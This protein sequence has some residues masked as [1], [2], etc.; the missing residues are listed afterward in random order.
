MNALIGSGSTYAAS[1]ASRATLVRARAKVTALP[2]D[3]ACRSANSSADASHRCSTREAAAPTGDS[4]RQDG[5]L[6]FIV[7]RDLR[8]ARLEIV[9]Y[10]YPRPAPGAAPALRRTVIASFALSPF[11]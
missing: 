3:R 4:Y 9:E 6:L 10:A 1:A 11:P 8:E 2:S 5:V 7:P